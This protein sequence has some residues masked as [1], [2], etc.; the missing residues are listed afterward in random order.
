MLKRSYLVSIIL[1]KIFSSSIRSISWENNINST[2]SQVATRGLPFWRHTQSKVA[3]VAKDA[4]PKAIS[5]EAAI[6]PDQQASS[7]IQDN[8]GL[9]TETNVNVVVV[10]DPTT[11]PSEQLMPASAA[12]NPVVIALV[13]ENA[14]VETVAAEDSN[15]AAISLVEQSLIEPVEEFLEGLEPGMFE[16]EDEYFVNN[17]DDYFAKAISLIYD[18]ENDAELFCV[19]GWKNGSVLQK[20]KALFNSSIGGFRVVRILCGVAALVT[21]KKLLSK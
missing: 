7:L 15:V 19:P 10:T 5:R 17:Q 21:L 11:L 9:S 2:P 6:N 13:A 3:P 16:T 12:D 8:G 18:K 14:P 4:T 20:G 1:L